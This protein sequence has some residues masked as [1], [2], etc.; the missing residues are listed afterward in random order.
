MIKSIVERKN[1]IICICDFFRYAFTPLLDAPEDGDDEEE[2]YFVS[3]MYGK[4]LN[5]IVL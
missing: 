2:E 1:T 4:N 5:F 3:D